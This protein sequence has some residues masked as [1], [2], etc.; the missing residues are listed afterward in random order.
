[1]QPLEYSP[2][3]P[4]RWVTRGTKL[5][6][7]SSRLVGRADGPSC[8]IGPRRV[9]QWRQQAPGKRHLRQGHPVRRP[10]GS[11]GDGL[12]D[13]RR[14]RGGRRRPGDS[15]RRQ[16]CAGLGHDGQRERPVD[17]RSTQPRRCALEDQRTARL[18]PPLHPDR[19]G[20]RSRRC[21]HSPDD[22]RNPV[23][24]LPHNAVRRAPRRRGRGRRPAGC[25]PVRREHRQPRGGRK[26]HHGHYRSARRGRV[27]LAEQPRSAL[28]AKGFL[29]ARHVGQRGGQHLRR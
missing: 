7:R 4:S 6:G 1:M 10:A 17:R 25:D 22:L 15:Q 9:Q 14:R 2:V 3:V 5:D 26:G 27:L 11:Q 29:E 24:G 16:R 28:A 23:A 13:R 21:G 19:Q 8:R 20:T 18:Q 12:G